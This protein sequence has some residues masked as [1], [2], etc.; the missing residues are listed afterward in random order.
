MR[1]PNE[2]HARALAE[3]TADAFSYDRYGERGWRACVKLLIRRGYN[4]REVEAILRSKWMRWAGDG[5]QTT[6]YGHHNS[7]DL[8]RFL[9]V[10]MG[11]H[12]CTQKD[13]DELVAGTFTEEL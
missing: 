13:V 7:V 10:S 12:E 9:D 2:A 3:K 5:A 1:Q 11:R 8:A 4:D 6:R